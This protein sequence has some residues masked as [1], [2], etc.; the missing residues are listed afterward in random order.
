[1]RPAGPKTLFVIVIALLAGVMFI[2]TAPDERPGL[3]AAPSVSGD[4]GSSA[5]DHNRSNHLV[6]LVSDTRI[7]YWRIMA[8]GIENAAEGYGYAL[9]VYDARNDPKKELEFTA[10]AI[11]EKATGIV[12]SPTTSSACTTILKLAEKAG[13]PVVIADIGTDGGQYVSYIASDNKTGAYRIGQVL[14][15]ALKASG[16]QGGRVGIIAIPQKRLNGQART[17]GFMQALEEAG[18][19]GAGIKQQSTFSYQETYDYTQELIARTPDLRAVWLQGSDRYRGALDAIADAGKKN[20]ILLVTFDAEPEFLRLIPEGVLLGS[21]MQ[22]PYLMGREAVATLDR[23]LRGYPVE[24]NRLLPVLA[25]SAD[26]IAQELPTIR[27]NVLGIE[28]ES[29]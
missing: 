9:S 19:K 10:R 23:H 12:V 29:E 4:T 20:E 11:R 2:V 26:N 21:A 16:R 3:T 28:G 14:T 5:F 7:P 13:I 25:V 1:M 17:A 6:Y 18:Y 22:Q 27:R 24:K 15:R 8:R